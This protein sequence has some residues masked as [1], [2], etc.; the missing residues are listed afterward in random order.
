MHFS[1]AVKREMDENEY[2]LDQPGCDAV[3]GVMKG[4]NRIWGSELDWAKGVMSRRKMK[5]FS[6]SDKLYALED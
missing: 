1:D 6:D 4:F 2:L 3:A 5:W